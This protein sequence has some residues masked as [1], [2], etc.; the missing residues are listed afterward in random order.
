MRQRLQR[1]F[2]RL[3]EIDF[4]PGQAKRQAEDALTGL[5]RRLSAAYS[6]GEPHP[7]RKQV[8][9]GQRR[10][11][12]TVGFGQPAGISGWIASPAPGSS[13]DSSIGMR[14]SSGSIVRAIVR[15]NTIGFDFD[16]AEFT[17]ASNRVTF[18]VLRATFGLDNDPAL[19]KIGAAVHFLDVGGIPVADAKGL[20]TLLR[21]IKEKSRRRRC[22]ARRSDADPG[23]LLFRLRAGSGPG[24][25]Q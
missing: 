18:E 7:S 11:V 8:A 5:A 6:S 21:G 17:H 3:A 2:D 15:G 23:S 14:G 9:A 22:A 12:S 4:F 20:E 13:S 1:S 19:V 16:G 25:A 24:N 10:Q